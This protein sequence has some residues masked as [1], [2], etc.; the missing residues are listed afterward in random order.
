MNI[1]NMRKNIK[2]IQHSDD[3]TRRL[4]DINSLNIAITTVEELQNQSK[5]NTIHITRI[6]SKKY[7]IVGGIFVI[8]AV[9]YLGIQIG[10]K[11]QYYEIIWLNI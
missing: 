8:N 3:I 9:R 7:T 1:S 6:S 5:Q 10:H 2:N 4:K 11:T